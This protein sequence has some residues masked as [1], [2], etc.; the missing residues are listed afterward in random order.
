MNCGTDNPL[1]AK[2][3]AALAKIA[4]LEKQVKRMELGRCEDCVHF[5]A[6]AAECEDDNLEC[7]YERKK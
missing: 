5:N 1:I 3:A 7:N 6:R 4:E 2:L